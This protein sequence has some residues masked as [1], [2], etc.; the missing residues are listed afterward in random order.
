MGKIF[1]D[2]RHRWMIYSLQYVAKDGT[3]DE[4]CKVDG[5]KKE[6]GERCSG[7]GSP[8]EE[9]QNFEV[10]ITGPYN[11]FNALIYSHFIQQAVLKH[12]SGGLATQTET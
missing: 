4:K 5:G 11:L 12:Y 8:K 10:G 6:R 2:N 3:R 1:S 9:P 7:R